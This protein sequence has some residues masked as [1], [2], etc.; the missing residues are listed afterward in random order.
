MASF[1]FFA[2]SLVLAVACGPEHSGTP[3]P[4]PENQ[5]SH[6]PGEVDHTWHWIEVPETTCGNGTST[7]YGLSL[8]EDPTRLM[9]F[10][11]GGGACW[12]TAS[13]YVFGS[14]VNIETTVNDARFEAEI[15][16]VQNSGVVDRETGPFGQA[17]FVYIPYCTGDFHSGDAVGSYD[18]LNPNRLV[19]HKGAR[20]LDAYAAILAEEFP[21]T[22]EVFLLGVSAG[23]YGAMM[24][25]HR[26]RDA[27]PD[28]QVH[29]LADGSPMVHPREGRWG[30]WKNAWNMEFPPGCETCADTF[31]EFAAEVVAASPES[32]FS[33]LTWHEDA[34]VALFFA[35]GSGLGTATRNLIEDTYPLGP[36]EQAS[37]FHTPGTDHVMLQYF[38]TLTDDDGLTLR[39]YVQAWVDGVL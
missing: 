24:N 30:A 13:C 7:G 21:L 34:T 29:V 3:A 15:R 23:G 16:P 2:A 25:H 36:G 11:A 17:S 12:D 14:A 39:D 8:G 10:L 26:F 35:Y 4:T 33:L 37:A 27:F 1:R 18:P 32:R 20:N 9:V 28:A 19:H 22:E 5:N 31:P 38:D 6:Q